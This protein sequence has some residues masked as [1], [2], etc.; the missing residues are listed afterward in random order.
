M[1]K[2]SG[3]QALPLIFFERESI[4][5]CFLYEF[6]IK[7]PKL[8]YS[9]ALKAARDVAVKTTSIHFLPPQR[10]AMSMAR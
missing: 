2:T 7:Q 4:Y 8:F 6:F 1:Q 5:L 10:R 9:A 3:S